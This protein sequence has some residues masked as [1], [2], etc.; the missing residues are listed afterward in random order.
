MT[1]EKTESSPGRPRKRWRKTKWFYGIVL[2][3]ATVTIVIGL[4]WSAYSHRKLS[5]VV[6]P[7]L[8]RGE[9]LAWSD[10][11]TDPIPDDQNAAVL[12]KQAI[13]TPLVM[14]SDGVGMPRGVDI[15][16]VRAGGPMCM[17]G[18]FLKKPEVRRKYPEDLRELLRMAEDV[19]SLCRKARQLD[20]VDWG[21]NFVESAGGF[22]G[23]S[24]MDSCSDIASLL[25]LAAIVAH[26]T[27]RDGEAVEYLQDVVALG[28]SLAT[29]PSFI[30]CVNS[31]FTYTAIDR[32]LEE[33]LPAIK[34]GDT[35]GSARPQ[36]VR[37]LIADLLEMN[38][39]HE[40]ATL[41]VMGER[42][43]CYDVCRSML[44]LDPMTE[45]A[46]TGW[47][48]GTYG[49]TYSSNR[50]VRL[51]FNFVV[52]PMLRIDAAWIMYRWSEAIT[53]SRARTLPEFRRDS[54][55]ILDDL[56]GHSDGGTFSRPFS[57]ATMLRIMGDIFELHYGALARRRLTGIA[58]A[59]RMHQ[60]QRGRLP[61]ALDQLVP[62][63]LARIPQDPMDE[64]GNPICY[65]N[66]PDMP[67]LYS[68]GKDGRDDGGYF[69]DSGKYEYKDILFFLKG[70]SREPQ[71]KT[72]AESSKRS[73]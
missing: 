30:S 43:M 1:D 17:L 13:D 21:L 58:L 36:N 49:S 52:A 27:G 60:V 71:E 47:V 46:E 7:I 42:S 12:Y 25:C 50:P 54:R 51:G 69:D 6:D 32:P 24:E 23:R 61:D 26:E 73:H 72:D 5:E 59:V 29:I 22:Y 63:Y 14:N 37:R 38:Q 65:V 67:R 3:Y 56:V 28:D 66:D 8:A 34:I 4:S 39:C 35:P 33:I 53:V 15:E 18:Y 10:F 44:S 20:K 48:Q 68:V 64:P 11:A 62:D 40:G 55:R 70:R 9:P 31:A 45:H 2:A 19:L 16:K 41:A 57:S